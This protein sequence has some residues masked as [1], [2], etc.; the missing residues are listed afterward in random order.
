M[1]NPIAFIRD[2]S[3]STHIPPNI[4][5]NVLDLM[6]NQQCSVPFVARYRKEVI[7]GI[8][9]VKIR[10]I[11]DLH[12]LHV[13]TEQRRAFVLKTIKEM[14][15][16][17]PDLEKKINA[18]TTLNQLEDLYAP[19]KAKKKTKGMLAKEKGLQPLADLL[20]STELTLADLQKQYESVFVK[21]E[22][23]V[24]S[25]EEALN[26]AKDIIIE[27][28][29]H[30]PEL[31]EDF[32]KDFWNEA[33]MTS[34][35]KKEAKEIEDHHKYK[36]YFEYTE[37]IRDLKEKKATHRFM[38][39]R[40]GMNEKVLSVNVTFDEVAALR[41]IER[42]YPLRN[43]DLMDL[44][45]KCY[46]RAYKNYIHPSLDLE[47]KT[48]LKKFADD[49]AIEIFKINL[50][51]VLLAPYLGSK[52]VMGVDPG[53]R[54]G[55]KIAVI[56]QTGKYLIDTIIYPHP[57]QNFK[58]QSAQIMDALIHQFNIEYIAIGNGTYSRETLSF[59]EQFVSA[60]MTGKVK[61]TLTSEAG[62]SIYSTSDV[63][64]KEFPDK[65]P[66]VRSSISIA[67][68]FQDPLAELVKLDPKSIGVGQ[69]QHD[70]NQ[71]M[72]K[73]SLGSVVESCVNF[74]GVDLNTASASLLSYISGIGP[75]LSEKIVSFR[76]DNGRFLNRME[77]KKVPR[78][79]EKIFE[80]AA[81]FLR[82]YN[83]ENP[84]DGTFIHPEQY[85]KL[86]TWAQKHKISMHDLVHNEEYIIKMQN[87]K[88]LEKELGSYTLS[89]II[90]SLKSPCQDPRTEFQSTDFRKDLQDINDL[91]LNEWYP[92]IVTNIA[93]FGA[94]VDIGIKENGLLH[95][96]EICDHFVENALNEL[97]VG[98]SVKVR[99][100]SVDFERRRI[101]LSRKT[102]S[103]DAGLTTTHSARSESKPDFK[104]PHS[105]RDNAKRNQSQTQNSTPKRPSNDTPLKNKAFAGL[106]SFKV[107]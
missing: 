32:R 25:F 14:E 20:L 11:F 53:V 30:N 47:I 83:G 35:M 61:A 3:E 17:T 93:Q 15:L 38:A 67:R 31:K 105:S 87:D 21:T 73:K 66:T 26:G 80:Q 50:K 8:D 60:V 76:E 101:S 34:T 71:A 48:D 45:Q 46:E 96:S 51:N 52:A 58:T 23:G 68:R 49:H 44:L 28:I 90:K 4:V 33:L 69:Y 91:K 88:T 98:Q 95:I 54:T 43:K 29:A 7:G 39:I 106:K 64:R 104:H 77:L 72:L 5:N 27:L 37:P 10:E 107:K 81:G 57:P 56:D 102:V 92:G 19:Y 18:A 59:L 40:R 97:K 70:V 103:T 84:L 85:D 36:D 65:D 74:V 22:L 42:F 75:S 6:I 89:D 78:F 86:T 13:E 63:A 24:P 94:F 1:N 79:S 2:I 62:A 100:T 99:I 82:I 9:E 16:L 41:K 55:C 12:E